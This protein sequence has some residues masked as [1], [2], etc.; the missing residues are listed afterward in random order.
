MADEADM[1]AQKSPQN[2]GVKCIRVLAAKDSVMQAGF[3]KN[4]AIRKAA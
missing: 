1:P 4:H 3:A 2:T